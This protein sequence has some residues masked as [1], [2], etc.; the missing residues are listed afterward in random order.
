MED[1][2]SH[3][4][5]GFSIALTPENVF[6]CFVGALLGTVIGVLPGLGPITAIAVLLP[7]TYDMNPTTAVIMLCGMYYGATYGGS[8]TSV[9]VNAPGE[10]SSAVTCLDGFQ[11]AKQGR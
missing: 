11:M 8:T 9:L 5:L 2:L 4:S 7:L 3:L 6:Y 10:A 1:F